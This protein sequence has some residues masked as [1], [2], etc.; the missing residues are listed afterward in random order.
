MCDDAIHN[1]RKQQIIGWREWLT[2]PELG[3]P[4]IKVKI[5]TGART[6]ALHVAHLEVYTE[7]SQRKVRFVLHPL[8]RRPALEIFCQAEVIDER[9]VSD[10][11]G[12]REKRLVIRTPLRLGDLQWPVEITLTNRED[13]LF[14]MLLGRTAMQGRWLV[15]P[16]GSYFCGRHLRKA[17][18]QNSS[19]P[20]RIQ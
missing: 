11:G 3:V 6:S 17:Y 5:D 4:A 7:H 8:R 9:V 20:K 2:L 19:R 18:R 12:H 1:I 10:S 16:V 14:R 15:D 13:M